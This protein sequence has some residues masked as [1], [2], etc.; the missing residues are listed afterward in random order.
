VFVNLCKQG[1][2][3]VESLDKNEDINYLS[4]E[5]K[6]SE[7]LY[8]PEKHLKG[9]KVTERPRLHNLLAFEQRHFRVDMEEGKPPRH[10]R[11]ATQYE[12]AKPCRQ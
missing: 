11:H 6:E 2:A 1:E 9:T 7:K 12:R 4:E 3:L 10:T 8:S 5:E